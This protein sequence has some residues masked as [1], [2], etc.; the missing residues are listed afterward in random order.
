MSK[1]SSETTL[2]GTR[3]P[4]D[5]VEYI[6]RKVDAREFSTL[7]HGVIRLITLGIKHDQEKEQRFLKSLFKRSPVGIGL[8]NS[9]GRILVSNEHLLKLTGYSS[10]E[11]EDK[12]L[13][14]LYIYQDEPLFLESFLE[15]K[16]HV[17]DYFVEMRR[18]DGELV[19]MLLS[20][21][22]LVMSDGDRYLTVANTIK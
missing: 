4:N 19:G 3:L 9:Q 17:R 5:I 1:K 12:K 14:D 21:E 20:V 15:G 11:M 22:R 16:A 18:T 13:S 7:S 10:E 2:I 6:Q 8:A